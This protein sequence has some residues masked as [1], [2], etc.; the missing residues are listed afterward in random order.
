M[1]DIAGLP[2]TLYASLGTVGTWIVLVLVLFNF[3][4]FPV[5][6]HIRLIKTVIGVLLRSLWFDAKHIHLP[7]KTR[8]ALKQAWWEALSPIGLN[9]FDVVAVYKTWA[10]PDDCDYNL[11][12][13]NSSYAKS[14]DV[15]RMSAGMKYLPTFIRSG[16]FVIAGATHFSFLREIRMFSKY[17]VHVSIASWDEKW[18]FLVGRFVTFPKK[19]SKHPRGT[20]RP[21]PAGTVST[22]LSTPAE[23]GSAP[24]PAAV[25][26]ALENENTPPGAVLHTIGIAQIVLK[27]GRLTVPPGVAL[28]LEGFSSEPGAPHMTHVREMLGKKGG[29]REM[30]KWAVGGWKDAGD[31][32][33][34]WEEAL[35]GD[36]EE[37]RKK[38]IDVLGVL[39]KGMEGVRYMG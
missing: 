17:E 10:G 4:S 11:H 25:L 12:L 22:P 37:K 39:R 18:L 24:A 36:V 19:G 20:S 28:A 33:R 31:G 7:K 21:G 34:W 16:G 8:A 6:W 9:P 15:A 32:E 2:V 29:L 23:Q 30:K 5:G 35:K 1:I 14:F 3:R 27:Q 26:A 13:N 38:N